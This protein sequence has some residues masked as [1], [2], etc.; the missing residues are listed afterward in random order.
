M[1][2]NAT[3]SRSSQV[4]F[5]SLGD[6]EDAVLLHLE[7]AAYFSLNPLGALIWELL[8]HPS[9]LEAIVAGVQQAVDDAPANLRADVKQF[10]GELLERE[11]LIE[12]RMPPD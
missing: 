4:V 10:M 1:T 8:E 9:S 7:T 3:F 12:H 11:L 5:Q 2:D 6:G